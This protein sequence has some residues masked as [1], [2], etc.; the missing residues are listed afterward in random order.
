MKPFSGLPYT[1]FSIYG[2][3]KGVLCAHNSNTNYMQYAQCFTIVYMTMT[4]P[5]MSKVKT[6]NH[7]IFH[8]TNWIFILL[9]LGFVRFGSILSLRRPR[10]I[11]Y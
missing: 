9:R 8:R 5:L 11:V 4:S 1:A 6:R 2:S 7:N 3:D 10:Q